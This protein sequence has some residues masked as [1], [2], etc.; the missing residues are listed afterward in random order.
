[1]GRSATSL[2][3]LVAGA[4]CAAGDATGRT[5]EPVRALAGETMLVTYRDSNGLP[6]LAWTTTDSPDGWQL[7]RT[8]NITCTALFA[9]SGAT[10]AAHCS[11]LDLGGM[12]AG[13][14]TLQIEAVLRSVR[15][16]G[17]AANAGY[18]LS[19]SSSSL[20]RSVDNRD[21]MYLADPTVAV[22]G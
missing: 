16:N 1:M 20:D 5:T 11:L 18:L 15:S 13:A 9:A 8:R 14:A 3:A 7:I 22:S 6:M 10:L 17:D 21:G 19:D 12:P 4:G 2:D